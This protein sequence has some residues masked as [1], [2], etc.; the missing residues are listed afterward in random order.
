MALDN[1]LSFGVKALTSKPGKLA[2][3]IGVG[4]ML[5]PQKYRPQHPIR[6]PL[7]FVTGL[8]LGGGFLNSAILAGGQVG[9]EITGIPMDSL[10][11][12]IR[13]YQVKPALGG[14]IF[15]GANMPEFQWGF[16]ALAHEDLNARYG[17]PNPNSDAA[18]FQNNFDATGHYDGP[19]PPSMVGSSFGARSSAMNLGANGSMV[20]GMYNNRLR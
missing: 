16:S 19:A 7:T 5:T 17:G 12:A 8:A 6:T 14:A 13:D 2:A 15:P 20:F 3:G 10:W 11:P 9:N 18:L 1:L 4:Y